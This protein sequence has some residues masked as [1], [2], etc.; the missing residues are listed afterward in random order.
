MPLKPYKQNQL[1]A[2]MAADIQLADHA[3]QLAIAT[4]DLARIKQAK[5]FLSDCES[6]YHQEKRKW[7]KKTYKHR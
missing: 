3:Y 1:L 6:D 7:F 2:D 4:G 5:R